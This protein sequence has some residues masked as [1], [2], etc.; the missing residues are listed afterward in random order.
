VIPNSR[1]PWLPAPASAATSARSVDR[2]VDA[3]V[4]WPWEDELGPDSV[5]QDTWLLSFADI[6]MLLLTLFVLLLAYKD[7]S[8]VTQPDHSANVTE[9]VDVVVEPV[10]KA[11]AAAVLPRHDSAAIPAT[12]PVTEPIIIPAVVTTAEPQLAVSEQISLRVAPMQVATSDVLQPT[13]SST[14]IAES[15]SE[16]RVEPLTQMTTAPSL[17]IAATGPM[18]L[19]KIAGMPGM[20]G[21]PDVFELS[22]PP[23]AEQPIVEH[24]A[25]TNKTSD[26]LLADLQDSTLKDRVEVTVMPDSVNLEISDSI[27]FTPASAALTASGV[28][29]L[30]ELA[31]TLKAHPYNLS[32]EGHTDNVPIQTARYPSNWELS[33]SR[34]TEV[35][36]RLIDRGIAAERVRAVGYADTHPRADNATAEG[37]S[38]NRRVSLVLM[39]VR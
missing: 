36:R 37:K 14:T 10:D 17:R 4:V 12:T 23:A 22:P 25:A 5:E 19:A 24:R 2:G 27:L 6:L 20:F 21:L 15:P 9:Q 28:Q 34:A 39:E 8:E 32:V 33:S 30:D 16:P 18:P 1:N 11:V 31:V 3:D 38:R 29:L 13:A 35:T 26:K 7:G